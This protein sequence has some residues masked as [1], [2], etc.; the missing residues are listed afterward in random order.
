MK[1]I[2]C[3]DFYQSCNFKNSVSDISKLF[4]NSSH[5]EVENIN[6]ERFY[7]TNNET[8]DLTK[9]KSDII[10]ISRNS[11]EKI[12]FPLGIPVVENI[13]N[14]S[15]CDKRN[16]IAKTIHE[17]NAQKEVWKLV[18]GDESKSKIIYP[19]I[20]PVEKNKISNPVFV[21]GMIQDSISEENYSPWVLNA[22]KEFE[23]EVVKTKFIILGG[24][25]KYTNQ[26]KVLGL[27]NFL[28]MQTYNENDVVDFFS[29]LDVFYHGNFFGDKDLEPII[30]S[31]SAGIPI[32]SHFGSSNNIRQE[33]I[34]NC[35]AVHGHFDSYLAELFNLFNNE[36]YRKW[37]GLSAIKRYK[38]N[39][40]KDAY[41]E[42]LE[43]I[44]N[45]V[46]IESE[47]LKEQEAYLKEWL[48][49]D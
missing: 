22:Y 47:N 33:I 35:G 5:F 7:N 20:V 16:T 28:Q 43:K 1:K 17:N 27:K 40:S 31:L 45:E 2:V 6:K 12:L 23:K 37:L 3:I 42:N 10:H 32:I 14:Y 9:I 26:A 46:C 29:N 15:I 36:K 49:N 18:S 30:K 4:I 38:S 19:Y 8:F 34:G 48:E 41:I 25:E 11:N 44:Y 24:S 21:C 39:F 13:Q